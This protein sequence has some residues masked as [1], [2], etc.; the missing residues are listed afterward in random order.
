VDMTHEGWEDTVKTPEFATW[1]KA[2]PAEVQ[3]LAESVQAR[4]AITLLDA[5]SGEVAPPPQQTIS[6][7]ASATVPTRG[8]AALVRAEET[9]EEAARKAFARRSAGR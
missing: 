4:D 7:M 9:E 6:R 3:V 8:A 2:Q 1:F 5:Y